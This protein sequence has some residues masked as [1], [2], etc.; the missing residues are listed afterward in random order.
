MQT[1]QYLLAPDTIS[2]CFFCCYTDKENL[3]TLPWGCWQMAREISCFSRGAFPNYSPH[4]GPA[5]TGLSSP[6]PSTSCKASHN[7][8]WNPSAV[9]SLWL[10]Q[11]LRKSVGL[12]TPAVRVSPCH[13]KPQAEQPNSCFLLVFPPPAQGVGQHSWGHGWSFLPQGFAALHPAARVS[14]QQ[15]VRNTE[16]SA[17][18]NR[19]GGT[20]FYRK[21]QKAEMYAV[22][23]M[24]FGGEQ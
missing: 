12:G 13:S 18:K 22:Q 4:P 14:A 23:F 24:N 19:P 11:T 8:C 6:S 10:W 16:A 1:H 2:F 9:P 20:N 3:N 5:R 15:R 17:N 21:C 7:Q